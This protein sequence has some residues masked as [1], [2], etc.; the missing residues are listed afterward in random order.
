[1]LGPGLVEVDP[2]H[3]DAAV[4]LAPAREVSGLAAGFDQYP[5]EPFEH[6]ALVLS[7]SHR[8]LGAG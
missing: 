8:R 5:V 7:R 4:G 1:V 2:L 3:P 6:Q